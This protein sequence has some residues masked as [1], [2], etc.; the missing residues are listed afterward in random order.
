V[1]LLLRAEAGIGG[2]RL[3]LGP[4]FTYCYSPFGSLA[5]GAFT[6]TVLRTWGEPLG[7]EPN[8]TYA[9]GE[10]DVGLAD[11]SIGLGLLYRVDGDDD[12]WLFTWS[13]GK[14]F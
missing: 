7:A 1:G 9:G 3:D 11:W 6:A 10:F 13:L 8:R 12:R 14:G 4:A 5:A 2:G